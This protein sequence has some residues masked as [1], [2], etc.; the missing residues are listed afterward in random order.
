MSRVFSTAQV[1]VRIDAFGFR[2]RRHGRE[3]PNAADRRGREDA[4]RAIES[5][6]SLQ[7]DPAL[8]PLV[9]GVVRVVADALLDE[10]VRLATVLA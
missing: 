4:R 6:R 3:E 5:Q 1:L 2:K 8:R 7:R 10:V 9:L